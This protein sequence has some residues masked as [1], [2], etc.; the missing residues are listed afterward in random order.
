M[1]NEN[2]LDLNKPP[3]DTVHD[4]PGVLVFPPALLVGT[5]LLGLLL[6]I[7]WPWSLFPASAPVFW[8]RAAACLLAVSGAWLM[9]WGRT[10]MVRAG[11]NVPPHKPTLAIVTAGPFRY[12]RNPLYLGGTLVYLGLAMVLRSVWLLWLFAPIVFFF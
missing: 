7:S 3:R 4:S 12:T 11:T 5:L 9:I 8:I 2:T 10:T 1:K 6:G